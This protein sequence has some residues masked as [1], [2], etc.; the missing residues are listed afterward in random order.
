MPNP[1]GMNLLKQTGSKT[2]EDHIA[3]AGQ[4]PF[5]VD[6]AFFLLK[7]DELFCGHGLKHMF[8]Q[9]IILNGVEDIIDIC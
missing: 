4:A 7:A 1:D 6:P 2:R 5:G 9:S 3:K 8:G